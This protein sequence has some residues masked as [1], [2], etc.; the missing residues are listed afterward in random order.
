M[1]VLYRVES[2]LEPFAFNLIVINEGEVNMP[3]G[4]NVR[5]KI[6]DVLHKTQA[7]LLEVDEGDTQSLQ[8]IVNVSRNFTFGNKV[9]YKFSFKSEGE[10]AG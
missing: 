1:F 5:K 9:T 6:T 4:S 3:D 2:V 7:K 8:Q 10:T